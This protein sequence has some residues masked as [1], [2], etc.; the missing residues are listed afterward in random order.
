[1]SYILEALKKDEAASDPAAA[2]ALALAQSQPGR[3]WALW[4]LGG[5]LLVNAAIFGYRFYA[6][7]DSSRT[8]TPSGPPLTRPDATREVVVRPRQ[9]VAPPGQQT[10]RQQ[11]LAP[12][13]RPQRPEPAPSVRPPE[14]A[15]TTA[16][17]ATAETLTPARPK[18][19]S[20]GRVLSPEEAAA[21][22]LLPPETTAAA[23]PATQPGETIIGPTSRPTTPPSSRQTPAAEDRGQQIIQLAELPPADR[24]DF[25]KLEFSTHI[26][27]DD[28]A[29]RAVVVNSRRLNEGESI[30]EMVLRA[31]TEEGI[32]VDYR[33]Y[34][35]AVSVI[36]EWK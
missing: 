22:N 31:V 19:P 7:S 14:P 18:A 1:M 10:Q 17:I 35:V 28:P 4:V 33:G 13:T 29:L 20:G 32:L 25:P 8:S 12:V 16:A 11:Q 34:R 24:Q 30:G 9:R 21:L 3:S 26:F 27:A 23:V 36:E 5:A 15:P 2:A 6:G